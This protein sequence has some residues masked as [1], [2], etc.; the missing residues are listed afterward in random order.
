MSRSWVRSLPSLTGVT[1]MLAGLLW[2]AR[3]HALSADAHHEVS[4]LDLSNPGH[5]VFG[6]GL[7]LTASAVLADFGLA[8]VAAFPRA[9]PSRR[10]LVPA[11]VASCLAVIG[12]AVVA[13]MARVG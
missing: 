9:T 1:V 7:I 13:T 3:L 4:L 2:D 5:I 11:V 10:L 12:L 6:L 8:W